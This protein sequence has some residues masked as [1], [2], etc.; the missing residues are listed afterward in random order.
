MGLTSS[1]HCGYRKQTS[2][3]I[4]GDIH[5][6]CAGAKDCTSCRLILWPVGLRSRGEHIS[7]L[8]RRQQADPTTTT[9][10][11]ET[12]CVVVVVAVVGVVKIVFGVDTPGGA[13]A[14]LTYGGDVNGARCCMAPLCS[15]CV[16]TSAL[17]RTITA[18]AAH[19]MYTV[20]RFLGILRPSISFLFDPRTDPQWLR[21]LFL[22]F[23]LLLGLLSSDFQS[24]KTF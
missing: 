11:E 12:F 13:S 20:K 24:T 3:V 8:S 7:G 4:D 22:L 19:A 15:R 16:V 2:D 17:S 21:T 1:F 14:H 23:L 5:C 6:R 9:N 10:H 18:A